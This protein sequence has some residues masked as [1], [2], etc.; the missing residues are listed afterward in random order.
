MFGVSARPSSSTTISNLDIQFHERFAHDQA[1]V[2][3]RYVTDSSNV[4][5]HFDAVG[6]SAIYRSEW[7]RLFGLHETVL[8]WANFSSPPGYAMQ[9]SRFFAHQILTRFVWIEDEDESQQ[10]LESE[11][12]RSEKIEQLRE[13]EQQMRVR[14]KDLLSRLLAQQHSARTQGVHFEKERTQL[15]ELIRIIRS[16]NSMLA[17]VRGRRLQ[18]QKG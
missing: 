14:C 8:S 16:L 13:A 15:L 12:E 18:Y 3:S 17:F 9:R 11:K 6:M 4:S 5:H 7:T 2:D 1:T 10:V